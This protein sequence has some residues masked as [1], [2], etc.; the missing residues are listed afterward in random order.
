MGCRTYLYNPFCIKI[1]L[2]LGVGNGERFLFNW[3]RARRIIRNP[4][5]ETNKLIVLIL[6]EHPKDLSKFIV[7]RMNN[8]N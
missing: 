1:A 3:S 6:W 5:I 8:T 4:M 2:S 7:K